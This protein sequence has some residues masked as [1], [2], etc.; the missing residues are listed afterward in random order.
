L[1][2]AAPPAG[3]G[4]AQADSR[5]WGQTLHWRLQTL[6]STVGVVAEPRERPIRERSASM[7]SHR[8]AEPMA[9]PKRQLIALGGGGFLVEP[10]NPALDLYI[11]SQ[12]RTARP[13]VSFLSTASGDSDANLVKFY[14]AFSGY[15]CSPSHLPFF[16]RT[17]GLRDY[18]L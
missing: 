9:G 5:S 1:A 16:K 17:P 18:L 8:G 12:A 14:S 6:E 2:A 10:D 3:G 11:L 4:P 15:D 7:V 13:A